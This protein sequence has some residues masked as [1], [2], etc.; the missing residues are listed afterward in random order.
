[1]EMLWPST[2]PVSRK[3]CRNASSTYTESSGDRLLKNPIT[4]IAGCCACA[5]SGHAAPA[6]PSSVMNSRL[7]I[8]S[9]RRRGEHRWRHVE[10]KRL[11][12]LEIDDQFVLGRRLHRQVGGL[13]TVENAPD[14]LRRAPGLVGP[15]GPVRDQ[16]AADD[17]GA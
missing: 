6:P 14:V 8:R 5:A 16:A 1:M 12:G 7:L 2:K 3:P 9:P 4:G 17:K 11:R 10:T 13:L 15:I